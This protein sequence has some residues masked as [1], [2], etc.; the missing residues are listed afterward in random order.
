VNPYK[1]DL[2]LA[3]ARVN[4]FFLI[5]W[6]SGL[7]HPQVR[8]VWEPTEKACVVTNIQSCKASLTVLLA[9][10][11][12]LLLIMLAG[13]LRIRRRGGGSLEI[14]RLLWKQVGRERF[15]LAVLLLVY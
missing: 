4:D 1:R 14:G 8:T 12:I 15:S 6:P 9:A 2:I 10:D 5:M 11:V 13:L 7:I 3:S